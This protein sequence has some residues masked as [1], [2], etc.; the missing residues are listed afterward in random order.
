MGGQPMGPQPREPKPMEPQP[1]K[2]QPN[3]ISLYLT[4]GIAFFETLFE[5]NR[6]IGSVCH[7]LTKYKFNP[8]YLENLVTS[9][10]EMFS[11]YNIQCKN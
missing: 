6:D 4:L 1:R 7:K 8:E 9:T 5:F 10:D 11:F 3:D 2:L